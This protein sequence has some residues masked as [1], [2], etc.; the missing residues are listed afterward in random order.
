[1]AYDA[2]I[3]QRKNMAYGEGTMAGS[4]FGCKPMDHSKGP[5]MAPISEGMKGHVGDNEKRG[6]PPPIKHTRGKMA[7]QAN[8]DHGPHG[9]MSRMGG[10]DENMA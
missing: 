4:D 1:M 7:S 9:F 8:A 3:S 2:G 10:R 6:A 5:M